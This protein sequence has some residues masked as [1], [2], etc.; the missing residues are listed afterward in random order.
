MEETVTKQGL[1]KER[2]MALGYTMTAS[3]CATLQGLPHNNTGDGKFNMTEMYNVGL[4]FNCSLLSP[5][6]SPAELKQTDPQAVEVMKDYCAS[7][8]AMCKEFLE[9]N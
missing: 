5:A 7:M 2:I 1:S 9:K 3:L 6:I 4:A 8:I